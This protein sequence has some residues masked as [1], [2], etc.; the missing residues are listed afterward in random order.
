MT[1]NDRIRDLVEE[2]CHLKARVSRVQSELDELK[3]ENDTLHKS[4]SQSPEIDMRVNERISDILEHKDGIIRELETRVTQHV[5]TKQRLAEALQNFIS[6]SDIQRQS[7]LAVMDDIEKQ[8][9]A[10]IDADARAQVELSLFESG[11]IED[12]DYDGGL[13]G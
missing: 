4:L 6:S 9:D 5:I 11:I 2:N 3:Q 10:I 8:E 12:P 13:L 7:A 1:T